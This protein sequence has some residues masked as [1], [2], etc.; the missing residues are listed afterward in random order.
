MGQH[1]TKLGDAIAKTV[2][3]Y[4]QTV[5]SLEKNVLTSARKFK[6]LRPANAGQLEEV[7]EIEAS[8]RRLDGGKW[9]MAVGTDYRVPNV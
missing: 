6:D 8:P 2:D 9:P 7:T 4:N 5:G 3:T 1:F